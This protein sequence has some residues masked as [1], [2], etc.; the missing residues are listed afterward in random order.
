MVSVRKEMLQCCTSVHVVREANA[1]MLYYPVKT[2]RREVDDF[3]G[4]HGRQMRCKIWA[5]VKNIYGEWNWTV[6]FQW[7]IVIDLISEWNN[8]INL[9]NTI[10]KFVSTK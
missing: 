5:E 2:D 6:T 9:I 3:I 4:V 8:I 1:A 10:T 7:L